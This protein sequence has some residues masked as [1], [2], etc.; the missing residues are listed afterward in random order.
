MKA[1]FELCEGIF[2]DD[3]EDQ[4]DKTIIPKGVDLFIDTWKD[5]H[6]KL[7]S[8]HEYGICWVNAG[9]FERTRDSIAD[10]EKVF[11][12][13]ARKN[14]I[15]QK[16]ARQLAV[17][18]NDVVIVCLRYC[19]K[20]N[21]KVAIIGIGNPARHEALEIN[22]S[23]YG[24]AGVTFNEYYNMATIKDPSLFKAARNA[25]I[26]ALHLILQ[27]WSNQKKAY[28]KFPGHCWDAIKEAICS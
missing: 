21:D 13:V 11:E 3:F 5:I 25:K 10:F 16:D 28:Y 26:D 7:G 15:T 2:G 4:L 12:K 18:E 20:P 17:A 1:L 27:T 9:N 19:A 23:S 24:P 8:S 6:F 14:K 22:K